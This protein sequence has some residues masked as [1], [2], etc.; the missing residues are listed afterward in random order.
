MSTEYLGQFPDLVILQLASLPVG[1]RFQFVAVLPQSAV[2]PSQ[3]VVVLLLLRPELT[4]RI[5]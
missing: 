3:F 2:V 5:L 1:V 4:L